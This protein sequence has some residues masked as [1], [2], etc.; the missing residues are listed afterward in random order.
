M[1]RSV[2]VAVRH[3]SLAGRRVTYGGGARPLGGL[4][5][6][7]GAASGDRPP[8]G[9][10]QPGARPWSTSPVVARQYPSWPAIDRQL[11]TRSATARENP[12]ADH[13][14]GT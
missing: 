2:G 8:P 4:V 11:V 9:I 3:E 6:R 13:Q 12:S 10:E 7:A 5:H 1:F 14:G